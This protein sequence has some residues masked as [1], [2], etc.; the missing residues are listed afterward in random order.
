MVGL[1]DKLDSSLDPAR[2]PFSI[3][4]P[5]ELGIPDVRSLSFRTTQR[6]FAIALKPYLL[7]RLLD[8][9]DSALFIDPDIVVLADLTSL[10]EAVRSHALTLVPH[11]LRPPTGSDRIERELVLHQAGAFNAG[12]VGVS[13][14]E[15]A[16][17]FLRWWQKRVDALCIH[18]VDRGVHYDQRWLDLPLGF[19]E[20]L[21]VHRDA[22]VNVAHWNLD[23]RPL[24]I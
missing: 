12:V 13:R 5:A 3:L 15:S 10:F 17:A 7:A 14:G 6:E 2:E 11:R 8:E 22:G 21:H 16:S 23:E 4:T 24:R 18:A 9:N 19:V 1:A 20:D